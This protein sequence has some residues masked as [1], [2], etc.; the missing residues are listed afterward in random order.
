MDE[1]P[2]GRGLNGRHAREG[3]IALVCTGL[4][5]VKRGFETF[6]RDL[7]DELRGTVPVTLMKGGGPSGRDEI[8]V[9]NIPRARSL[10]W[11]SNDGARAYRLEQRSFS[12]GMLPSLV[13]Q[14]FDVIH[15]MDGSLTG[16]LVRMRRLGFR[17]KLLFKNGGAH[18]PEHY[19]RADFVQLLTPL[20]LDEARAF[21][22]PEHRLFCVPLG[23]HTAAYMPPPSYDRAALRRRYGVPVNASV[24]LCVSAL[25]FS[26]K[27]V[28]WVI[29]EVASIAGAHVFLVLAGQR[30]P[31]SEEILVLASRLL[32]G[33][34]VVLEVPFDRVRELYWLADVLTLGSLREG[35]GRVIPEAASAGLPLCVHDSPH[36][37]WMTGH[38]AAVVDMTQ[39]GVLAD[40]LGE[41]LTEPQL[42]AE[43]AR[44]NHR[45]V[46]AAFDWSR[47]RP[48]Y[49][50]MY[51]RV[52]S[53]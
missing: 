31:E 11:F 49:L 51:D 32:P 24:V 20:Q 48:M 28:D 43:L 36:F 45:H 23:L 17:Y 53:A 18:T 21:G 42:G 44:D 15:Y 37:R 25:S 29:R 38:P 19:E 12:V 40:R 35:F 2:S 10:R 41:L 34:H 27:R 47:V 5:R 6:T 7:F 13:A 4:G 1:P 46:R 3:R 52:R 9:P 14:R 39:P 26:D 8:V 30:G 22:I 16:P 33:R 50:S